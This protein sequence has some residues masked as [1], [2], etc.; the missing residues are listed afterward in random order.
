M[1]DGQHGMA[2]NLA[3]GCGSPIASKGDVAATESQ[4]FA[5][6]L[7]TF[8]RAE[9]AASSCPARFFRIAGRV[10]C[11]RF[12]GPDLV[13]VLAPAFAHL[14]C[15]S[16]AVPDLTICCWDDA[17]AGVRTTEP[18]SPI[19]RVGVDFV[20]GSV[21]V[22]WE[23]ARRGLAAFDH[24]KGLALLRFSEVAA[25]PVWERA[26]PARQ[27]LHWW[28]AGLGMQLVH[29]AAVGT[30]R[31]GVLLVGRGGSGKSTTALAC[32]GSS[33]RYAADDYCLLSFDG[34]PRVHGV[35]ATGKADAAS[36]T[37]LPR[38]RSVF[39]RAILH[40]E[41]KSVIFVARDFPQSMLE[42]FPVRAVVVPRITAAEECRIRPIGPATALRAVAPSTMFQ[43]PGDR[44]G[45]F[46]RLSSLVRMVP[47][48]ELELSSDPAAAQPL[49]AR[50]IE[51]KDVST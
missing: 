39:K 37:R 46:A 23:P 38:L 35:Y 41:G 48:Y 21:R 36:V 8:R 13:P 44:G 5:D 18:P 26:A 19:D 40:V 31:G 3:R 32:V 50:L 11:M 12:V 33:L 1:R 6:T 14:A 24:S 17:S 29:A 22:A 42:S 47:C 9:E 28:A 51:G 10:V 27:I 16:S 2:T 25:V 20:D 43:L 30:P 4:F 15:E 34:L 49:L 45:T 7:E